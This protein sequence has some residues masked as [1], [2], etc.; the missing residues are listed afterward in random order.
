MFILNTLAIAIIFIEGLNVLNYHFLERLGLII[1]INNGFSWNP[2]LAASSSTNVNLKAEQDAEGGGTLCSTSSTE[3]RYKSCYFASIFVQGSLLLKPFL[4]KHSLQPVGYHF[5]SH[6]HKK[7]TSWVFFSFFL[8][9]PVDKLPMH[10][11][12]FET[13]TAPFSHYCKRRKC[14]FS[15]SS[16]ATR[17]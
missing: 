5:S 10:P 11:M 16:L 14:H 6:A 9:P 2:L 8:V 12:G 7:T 13:R 15:Q 17:L 1:I 3:A 4:F